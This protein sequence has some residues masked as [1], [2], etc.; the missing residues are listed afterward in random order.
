MTASNPPKTKNT[1]IS[2][3]AQSRVNGLIY[4]SGTLA[5]EGQ[6]F[7]SVFTQNI[8]FQQQGIRYINHLVQGEIDG[9]ARPF[10]ALDIGFENHGIQKVIQ[11]LY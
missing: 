1:N 2:I 10:G 7:G 8:A 6:V 11:W 3:G 9:R 5:L 4:C